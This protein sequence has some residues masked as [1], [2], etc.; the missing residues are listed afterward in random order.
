MKS[1]R[2]AFYMC[3]VFIFMS[4][5]HKNFESEIPFHSKFVSIKAGFFDFLKIFKSK[6]DKKSSDPESRLD[7]SKSQDQDEQDP[8]EESLE[9][10]GAPNDFSES[11]KSVEPERRLKPEINSKEAK[12][13]TPVVQ[14]KEEESQNSENH[15][16]VNP[17]NLSNPIGLGAKDHPIKS[18]SKVMIFSGEVRSPKKG[19]LSFRTAGFISKIH[20]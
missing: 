20:F 10:E 14:K 18:R 3:L 13:S 8:E 15:E 2:I 4:S 5:C 16:S 1:K 17:S 6:K 9:S 12:A 7:E 11:K 19:E